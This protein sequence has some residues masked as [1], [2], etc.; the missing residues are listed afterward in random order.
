MGKPSN[1]TCIIHEG[2]ESGVW[3]GEIAAKMLAAA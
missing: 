2:G 3:G 1:L